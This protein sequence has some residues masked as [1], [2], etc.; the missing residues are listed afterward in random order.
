MRVDGGEPAFEEQVWRQSGKRTNRWRTGKYAHV[1]APYLLQCCRLCAIA[2]CQDRKVEV[3]LSIGF[4][5]SHRLER[6]CPK[7]QQGELFASKLAH[8]FWM[9][10]A[11]DVAQ[12]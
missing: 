2:Y 3:P 4:R 9:G 11:H 5:T 8:P 7:D 12:S 10:K 6:L 1:H